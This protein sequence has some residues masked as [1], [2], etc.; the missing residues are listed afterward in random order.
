MKSIIKVF[1]FASL[2]FMSNLAKSEVSDPPVAPVKDCNQYKMQIDQLR[3]KIAAQKNEAAR[4]AKILSPVA[5]E[6]V[7]NCNK[8]I[9]QLQADKAAAQNRFMQCTGS[10]EKY[11]N[12]Q[13]LEKKAAA[14]KAAA[15]KAAAEKATSTKSQAQIDAQ[16]KRANLNANRARN[17]EFQAKR[18]ADKIMKE[19]EEIL[20]R[21]KIKSELDKT[22]MAAADQ[23]QLI[24]LNE[25]QRKAQVKANK[26][27]S[28]KANKEGIEREAA[29]NQ[30]AAAKEAA[31]NKAAAAKA[32]QLKEEKEDAA[33]AKIKADKAAA[34]VKYDKT[35]DAAV[36]VWA[37]NADGKTPDLNGKTLYEILNNKILKAN[38]ISYS[39]EV[40]IQ[41][42]VNFIVA[43]H[44]KYNPKI[45]YDRFFRPGAA[46]IFNGH[47]NTNY[48]A[49]F[50]KTLLELDQ[51]GKWNQMNFREVYN[52]EAAAV[53]TESHFKEYVK[54][55][56]AKAQALRTRR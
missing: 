50:K 8:I 16:E 13:Q 21:N 12:A 41:D 27:A 1:V 53:E 44:D 56:N 46:E 47:G 31:A 36:K 14:E 18:Q 17:D 37:Y 33:F 30:A 42:Q 49:V 48:N 25:A 54:R 9:Q 29:A 52:F 15:E 35:I 38:F 45:I 3:L 34:K 24:K 10:N 40:S 55:M 19:N 6:R 39:I 43:V 7:L 20:K 5:K 22:G 26:P 23:E 28:D 11:K 4:F 51:Q 2:L 32:R